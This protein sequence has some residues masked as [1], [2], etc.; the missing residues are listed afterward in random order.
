[1]QSLG[2]GEPSWIPA[3][4]GMTRGEYR[5]DVLALL[6]LLVL[7]ALLALPA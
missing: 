5:L 2:M 1:M 3:F 4:A 6:V 7:L